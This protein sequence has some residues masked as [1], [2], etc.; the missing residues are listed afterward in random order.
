MQVL[1]IHT[2]NG[3][4]VNIPIAFFYDPSYPDMKPTITCITRS[5]TFV[6]A[7]CMMRMGSMVA[8][9]VFNHA[10]RSYDQ[11]IPC[12]CRD[13]NIGDLSDPYHMCH[14]FNFMSGILYYK[15]SR[16]GAI[17]QLTLNYT[18]QDIA[19]KSFVPMFAGSG[20][21]NASIYTPEFLKDAYEWCYS[22]RYGY[23]SFVVFTHWDEFV[24]D[25]TVN[26]YFYQLR[27][28]SCR[29]TLN[30]SSENW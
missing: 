17:F 27:Y 6:P 12:N 3:A 18:A 24:Y 8:L 4:T 5:F 26:E 2:V 10:G 13:P 29:N 15:T 25:F 16:L 14:L 21:G 1:R 20:W 9:P 28:G 22:P 7:I 23:C 11:P 30:T 19:S